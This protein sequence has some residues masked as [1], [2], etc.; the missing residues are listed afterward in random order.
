L[1]GRQLSS[2][3]GYLHFDQPLS[4]RVLGSRFLKKKKINLSECLDPPQSFNTARKLFERK[5]RYWECRPMP[6]DPSVV[7]SPCDSKLIVG[8]LDNCSLLYLKGKFFDFEELLGREKGNWLN[9]FSDGHFAVF[10]LT[11]DKYH[12]NHVPVTGRVLDFYSIHGHYHSCNPAAV[13]DLVT[14]FSKNKRVVTILQTDVPEGTQMGLV[15]MVEIVA[16]GIGEIVQCYSEFGYDSPSGI[17]PGMLLRKGNPKSLYRP[18]SSTTLL[19][20]QRGRIQFSG[21]LV[22]NLYRKYRL[23]RYSVGFGQPLVETEL[24]VRSPIGSARVRPEREGGK[25]FEP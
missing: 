18:G 15:A 19:L 8:S 16:L 20:F 25:Y 2:L 21:D 14:P 9:S 23:S 13:I 5:I 22:A 11:P 4:S 17:E 24:N 6:E 1:T 12:Y 7:V 3:I 10:R